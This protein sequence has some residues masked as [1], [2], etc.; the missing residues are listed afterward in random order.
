MTFEEFADQAHRLLRESWKSPTSL[1]QELYAMLLGDPDGEAAARPEA[2]ATRAEAPSPRR[3]AAPRPSAEP[4]P[5][6]PSRPRPA[7]PPPQPPVPWKGHEPHVAAAAPYRP[8]WP[9]PDI[10]AISL[11][12]PDSPFLSQPFIA[13]PNLITSPPPVPPFAPIDAFTPNPPA[14]VYFPDFDRK[15]APDTGPDWLPIDNIPFGGDDGTSAFLGQVV[16]GSEASYSVTLYPQGRDGAAGDTVTVVVPDPPDADLDA[17][18][19]ISP[20][21][22]VTRDDD[23]IEY[24]YQ[25]SAGGAGGTSSFLGKVVSGSGDTYTVQLYPAG[26]EGTA[27]ASV[28]VKVPQI[29]SDDAIPADTWIAPV[30]RYTDSDG[31]V[32]YQFQP[33]VWL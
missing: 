28:T 1:A 7:S 27:G 3:E 29:A 18:T 16:S 31:V 21:L 17:E 33:P 5:S 14:W 2:V 19:W 25:P 8:D 24:L 26:K 22:K 9:K 13:A 4:A 10:K 15:R 23:T 11:P 12:L 6:P 20:V 30:M 32:H